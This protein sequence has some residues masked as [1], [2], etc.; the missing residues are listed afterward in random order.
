M[1]P[2]NRSW[3]AAVPPPLLQLTVAAAS[4]WPSPSRSPYRIGPIP[5]TAGAPHGKS[6]EGTAAKPLR[7]R[8]GP[9]VP[10]AA[11]GTT[12]LRQSILRMLEILVDATVGRRGRRGRVDPRFR[13]GSGQR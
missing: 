9:A 7:S 5:T 10:H 2:A 3:P 13:Q 11:E 4:A 6:S 12:A 8:T 1:T